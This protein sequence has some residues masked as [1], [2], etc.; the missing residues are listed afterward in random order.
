M[1]IKFSCAVPDINQLIS[2]LSIPQ[3]WNLARKGMGFGVMFAFII[4]WHRYAWPKK[5]ID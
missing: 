5:E 2:L 4:M 1:V 3:M